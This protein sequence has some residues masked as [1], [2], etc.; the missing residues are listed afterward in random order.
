MA[1]RFPGFPPEALQFLRDLEANN[2]RD[3]FQPRKEIYDEK[4]KKPLYELVTALNEELARFAPDY[5][6]D[7][8]KAVYRIYRDTRFS[9]DKSPYKTHAAA[10]FYHRT[11]GKHVAAGYYFHFSPKEL[12]VGG[13]LWAPGSKELL[14]VRRRISKEPET[15]RA[16]LA[17]KTFRK[18]LG[19]MSGETLKRPPK[20][21]DAEDPALDLLL[22]KQFLAG[23]QLEPQWLETPKAF[24]E[25]AKRFEAISPLVEFVNGAIAG[26]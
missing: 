11:L 20:G 21:F 3:W 6:T 14:A 4:V 1:A 23:A 17:D 2:D 25:I 26:R 22:Y 24:T 19:Q 12:L 10:S 9:N 7:P 15:L 18:L 5:R 16:I 13:G 8:S